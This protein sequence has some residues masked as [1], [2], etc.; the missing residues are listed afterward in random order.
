MV[1][2]SI[3]GYQILHLAPSEAYYLVMSLYD[4]GGSLLF[5]DRVSS[6]RDAPATFLIKD[7]AGSQAHK[8][9]KFLLPQRF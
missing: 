5:T 4:L 6:L 1:L 9:S 8:S 7:F 3:S 2:A